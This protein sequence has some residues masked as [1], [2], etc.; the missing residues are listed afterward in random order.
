[1]ILDTKGNMITG[2]KA[3]IAQNLAQAIGGFI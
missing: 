1:M 2:V 3:S